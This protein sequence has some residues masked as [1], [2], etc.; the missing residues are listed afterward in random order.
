MKEENIKK[1]KQLLDQILEI[2]KAQDAE[3]KRANIR[4]KGDQCVGDSWLVFH[5][6]NLKKL[7][8]EK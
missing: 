6:E 3:F 2:A 7:I 8:E 1:A 5:L 4:G